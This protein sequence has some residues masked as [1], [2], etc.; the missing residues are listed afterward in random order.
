LPVDPFQIASAMG[1][2]V[3][4]ATLDAGTAGQLV[5]RAGQDV[6]IYLNQYD[7]EGRRRFTCAH[8]IGHYVIHAGKDTD[9]WEYVDRRDAASST[10][11]RSQEIYANQFAAALLM[12]AQAVRRYAADHSPVELAAK[13]DVS[14]EAMNYRLANL[15]D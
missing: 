15:G 5:K 6:E 2:K 1:I 14:L 13:F 9:E 7:S 4:A 3:Y 12:P 11:T 10:G 8:E